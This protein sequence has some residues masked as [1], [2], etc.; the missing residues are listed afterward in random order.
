MAPPHR[1]ARIH[2]YGLRWILKSS[3]IDSFFDDKCGQ[4]GKI[5]PKTLTATALLLRTALTIVDLLRPV[6]SEASL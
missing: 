2:I 6:F 5:Q 1:F 3:C 4:V